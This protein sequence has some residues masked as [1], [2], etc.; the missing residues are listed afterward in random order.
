[1]ARLIAVLAVVIVIA[2]FVNSSLPTCTHTH[3]ETNT[4]QS[5]YHA[6]TT[7]SI[8]DYDSYISHNRTFFYHHEGN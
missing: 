6:V 1:M 5:D 7:G 3:E 2:V 8:T 4:V